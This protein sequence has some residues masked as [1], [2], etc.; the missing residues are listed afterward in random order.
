MD[1]LIRDF[2]NNFK[3]LNAEGMIKH[4]H[5]DVEFEDPAFGLLKGEQ[6]CNMWRM[7]C[8][9]QQDKNFILDYFDVHANTEKGSAKWEAEYTFS[10]TNRRVK[11]VI[12]ANF[13]FKD[14][15]IYRHYDD[16]NLYN[17]AIQ[18]LGFK[19]LLFG[20]TLFFKRSLQK[21]TAKMLRKFTN[22]NG[23]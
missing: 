2:Y 19:G 21:S 20:W 22:E 1:N 12:K 6:V 9:S 23:S 14:G 4:Y 10:K 17:W 13:E 8:E 5:P 15:K 7:L 16:F 11:N 3:N 18:A